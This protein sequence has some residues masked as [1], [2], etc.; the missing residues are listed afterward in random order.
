MTRLARQ[1]EER[2]PEGRTRA[3]DVD[4]HVSQRI[5][6]RRITLGLTQQQMADLI[7]VTY[8]QAHKYETGVNRISAGRLY[9]I[10]RALGV[11]VNYF[12]EGLD[13]DEPQH[14]VERRLLPQQRLLLDLARNFVNISNRKH[15]EAI[16]NLARALAASDAVEEVQAASD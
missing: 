13:T 3:H 11:D 9:H 15:Q 7:G 10:A 12:F 1:I 8:Q 2:L 14:V 4:L 16:C 6:Q 5:R